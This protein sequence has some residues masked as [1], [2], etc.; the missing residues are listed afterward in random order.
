VRGEYEICSTF[1]GSF[2]TATSSWL[3]C[4][5]QQHSVAI[6]INRRLFWHTVRSFLDM[7]APAAI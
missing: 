6:A 5:T 1:T 4:R 3:F 2:R 7:P